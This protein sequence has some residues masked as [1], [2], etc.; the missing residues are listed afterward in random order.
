M[1]TVCYAPDI[2]LLDRPMNPYNNLPFPGKELRKSLIDHSLARKMVEDYQTPVMQSSVMK[3]SHLSQ[4]PVANSVHVA[5]TT[6]TI[7]V[8][9]PTTPPLL[10]STDDATTLFQKLHSSPDAPI[11]GPPAELATPCDMPPIT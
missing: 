8:L 6:T 9:P 10:T 11:H 1:G 5:T 4:L 2:P 7:P 3:P